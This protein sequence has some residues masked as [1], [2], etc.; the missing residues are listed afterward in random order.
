MIQVGGL[1]RGGLGRRL[2]LATCLLVVVSGCTTGDGGGVMGPDLD[3][4][5]PIDT[6]TRIDPAMDLAIPLIVVDDLATG[7]FPALLREDPALASDVEALRSALEARDAVRAEGLIRSLLDRAGAAPPDDGSDPF[8][9][10]RAVLA[11]SLEA[12]RA[13]IEHPGN[14]IHPGAPSTTAAAAPGGEVP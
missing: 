5:A 6:R 12:L 11:L 13:V 7:A 3:A 9:V 2:S 8:A 10:D 1:C 4:Q 14:A